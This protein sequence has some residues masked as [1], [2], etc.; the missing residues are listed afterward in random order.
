M[1]T[2]RNPKTIHAPAGR[3]VH[4]IEVANPSRILFISGQVG[5]T[6]DGNLPPDPTDQFVVAIENVIR[7]LEAAGL[8]IEALTKVTIYAV[9]ELDATR[10]RAELDRLLGAHVTCSTFIYV[11]AL[12]RP[13][14]K[15]EVDAWAAA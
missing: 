10:R 1:N 13:E 9:E 11:A 7:N 5:E 12:F 2:P 15:V 3:Y 14:Y 4:Q 8:G 6:A